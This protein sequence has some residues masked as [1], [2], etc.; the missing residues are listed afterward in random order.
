MTRLRGGRW[1]AAAAERDAAA[2]SR[3]GACQSQAAASP[4]TARHPRTQ[5]YEATHQRAPLLQDSCESRRRGAWAPNQSTA[6]R[7]RPALP[8]A[9]AVPKGRQRQRPAGAV[10]APNCEDKQSRR[11]P[12]QSESSEEPRRHRKLNGGVQWKPDE[13]RYRLSD[14][15]WGQAECGLD[16]RR[17]RLAAR[18]QGGKSRGGR[19]ASAA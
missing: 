12:V 1:R 9:L 13:A 8:G 10:A 15:P 17:C 6:A 19:G 7:A 3:P 14:P 4:C 2:G 16:T 11:S 18:P 5:G